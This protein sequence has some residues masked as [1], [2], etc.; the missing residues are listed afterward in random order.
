MDPGFQYKQGGVYKKAIAPC[1]I[2]LHPITGEN[3]KIS[4]KKWGTYKITF[5]T[6]FSRTQK[7]LPDNFFWDVLF[8]DPN[9]FIQYGILFFS[10][11]FI[12][13]TQKFL[14]DLFFQNALF[15]LLNF[16][17]RNKGYFWNFQ[18]YV[19]CRL[20]S[21]GCREHLPYKKRDWQIAKC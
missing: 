9:F 8:S 21:V 17:F 18:N 1:T 2:S 12:S 16:Y 7:T 13:E 15:S 14:L 20:K 5:R 3:P 10:Q 4:L 11:I 19:G 6:P